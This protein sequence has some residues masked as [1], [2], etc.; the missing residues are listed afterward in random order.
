[1]SVHEQFKSYTIKELSEQNVLKEKKIHWLEHQLIQEIGINKYARRLLSFNPDKEDAPG[2]V[3]SDEV[4]VCE[5][6]DE[7]AYAIQ[8]CLVEDKKVPDANK[9]KNI[10]ECAFEGCSVEFIAKGRRKYCSNACKQA[11]Y[12]RRRTK[13]KITEEELK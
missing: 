4:G 8:A 11:D 10:R 12:R 1:M 6:C 3:D 2:C 9:K 7:I 5:H 13:I